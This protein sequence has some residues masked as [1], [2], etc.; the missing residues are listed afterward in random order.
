MKTSMINSIKYTALLVGIATMPVLASAGTFKT[1]T[2]DGDFSD[3]AG[4]PALSTVTTPSGTPPLGFDSLYMAN[5]NDFVYLRIVYDGSFAVNAGGT[6]VSIAL[7]NDNNP[8]TGFDIFTQGIVGS[9]AGWENDFP[10]QQATGV[11]N[12][13]GGLT[14]GGAAIAP[15]ATTVTEQEI[16]IS[17]SATF[18]VGGATI[19]PN[20][21]FA[22]GVYAGNIDFELISA[23]GANAYTVAV[24]EAS[25]AGIFIAITVLG[26]VAYRRHRRS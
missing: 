23:T 7:D 14:N 22:I 16:A 1:I 6:T 24:P 5:D 9:E 20:D 26:M 12:T 3:W 11:F 25:H 19:F 13:G 8:L 18:T 21:T 17:R 10:F 2:I 4:V 15:F